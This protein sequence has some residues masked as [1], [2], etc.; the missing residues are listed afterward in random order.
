MS[1]AVNVVLL[2]DH[3]LYREGIVTYLKTNFSNVHVSYSGDDFL[4]AKKYATNKTSLAV[5]DLHLGDGRSPSE[6]VSAFSSQ[7]IKVLVISALNN[8]D[9]V[10]TSF[11]MGASGFVSKDSPI[12]EIGKA[13]KKVLAG[14][15]WLSP[16]L[17]N[18]LSIDNDLQD[19]LSKQ[20]LK[21]VM[22]Y[23]SGLK[24][25]LVAR[26]M[27]V[28]SSTVKQY[29]DRSKTKFKAQ[30]YQVSTKTEIYKL[31]RDKGLLG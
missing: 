17:E 12:E 15:E 25:D 21:A 11:A 4:A 27:N 7:G 10:K 28:A 30:G 9:S 26:R 14:E 31:L 23:A 1:A 16:V 6:I 22:L 2:E 3:P 13:I 18:S 8:F 20:E 5:V 29:I 19:V 24:L